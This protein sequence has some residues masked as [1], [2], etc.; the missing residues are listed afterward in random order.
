MRKSILGK[1][2][3]KSYF[4]YRFRRITIE[5]IMLGFLT[6]RQACDKYG[7]TLKLI[8][9]WRRSYYK[10]RFLPHSNTSYMKPKKSKNKEI[11][12]LKAKLAA[13]EK[14][15]QDEKIKARAYEIM[16]NIAE[17]QF[18]IPIRKKSGPQQPM[19]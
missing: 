17:E 14:A 4:P 7:L 10:Y 11:E 1:K 9:K 13:S 15:Y 6:E 18:Q 3:K 2:E 16:I 8:R 12:A 19:N 5:K